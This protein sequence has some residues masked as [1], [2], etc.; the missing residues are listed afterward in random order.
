[1]AHHIR[2]FRFS[3]RTQI[4]VNEDLKMEEFFDE[5]KSKD[6]DR[7]LINEEVIPRRQA[8]PK[9][10]FSSKEDQP[11]T[12]NLVNQKFLI[13]SGIER[14]NQEYLVQKINQ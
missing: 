4:E 12:P 13:E 8:G 10:G 5:S 6:N 14:L 3:N 11:D 2:F 7:L 1:M 9:Y